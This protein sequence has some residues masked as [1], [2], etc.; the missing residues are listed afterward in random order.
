MSRRRF[1][2]VGCLLF[3]AGIVLWVGWWWKMKLGKQDCREVMVAILKRRLNY[4]KHDPEGLKRFADE[5]HGMLD[6]YVRERLVQ[7]ALFLPVYGLL[8]RWLLNSSYREGYLGISEPLLTV[9][10]L[11]VSFFDRATGEPDFSKV[12]NYKSGEI[13]VA[14]TCGN[15]WAN[16]SMEI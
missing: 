10:L 14:F 2:I 6:G 7:C 1:V 12:L 9:Y 16:L 8:D 3:L 15:P 13:R 5:Y 4:V 11:S